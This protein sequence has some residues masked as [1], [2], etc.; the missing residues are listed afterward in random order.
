MTLGQRWIV[1]I[2]MSLL[3]LSSW[4]LFKGG[5]G[6][7][8]GDKHSSRL[9]DRHTVSLFCVIATYIC[10]IYLGLTFYLIRT[11]KPS[12]QRH[13]STVDPSSPDPSFPTPPFRKQLSGDQRFALPVHKASS[14]WCW[15]WGGGGVGGWGWVSLSHQWLFWPLGSTVGVDR[16]LKTLLLPFSLV[17]Y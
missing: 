16:K 11:L 10:C 2:L 13:L 3:V 15:W 17:L 4:W 8:R 12:T 7:G 5:R 9:L 14:K 6:G 1:V